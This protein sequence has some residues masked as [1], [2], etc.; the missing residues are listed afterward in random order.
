MLAINPFAEISAVLPANAMQIYLV[1]AVLAVVVG[2][3]LDMIH[4]GSATYFFANWRKTRGQGAPVDVAS[5]AVKTAVV[6]VLASGEFC[7]PRR[8]VAHL[9]TMYGFVLYVLS[10]AVLVFGHPTSAAAAPWPQLWWLGGLMV[11]ANLADIMAAI[12]G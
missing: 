4:K 1:L 12:D 6:E 3:M 7:N 11:L 9:L 5:I 2:V 10:T 8:R